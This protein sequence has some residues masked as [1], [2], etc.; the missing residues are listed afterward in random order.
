MEFR[1]QPDEPKIG[2]QFK[3]LVVIVVVTIAGLLIWLP[4]S[5]RFLLGV[6]IAVL[7]CVV[8]GIVVAGILQQWHKRKPLKEENVE[9][10]R[11]LGL[12]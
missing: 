10:K 8:I 3:A 7:I 11:P 2:F 6:G 9:H 12:E 5:R 1:P 4:A